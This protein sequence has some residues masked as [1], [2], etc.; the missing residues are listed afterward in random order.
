MS[1]GK[2][3]SKMKE[4]R[5]TG[6]FN[7]F[8]GL[9]SRKNPF[10]VPEGYFETLPGQIIQRIEAEKQAPKIFQL[11]DF[12]VKSSWAVAASLL[13]LM[14]ISLYYWYS[15]KSQS[16]VYT[17]LESMTTEEIISSQLLE[18]NYITDQLIEE[19]AM[20]QVLDSNNA[21]SDFLSA[22]TIETDVNE[23]LDYLTDQ[24]LNNEEL[25]ILITEQDQ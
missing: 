1:K 2:I 25:A 3:K 19:V 7:E 8:Q 20:E 18:E 17:N 11:R 10:K 13:L 16:P 21:E 14:S 15:E 9:E 12:F 22:F 23:I 5:I 6:N 4:H 24:E